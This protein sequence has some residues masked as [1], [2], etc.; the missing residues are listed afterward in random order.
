M[1][2]ERAGGCWSSFDKGRCGRRVGLWGVCSAM[3][4]ARRKKTDDV[5]AGR[6]A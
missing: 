3:E 1:T 2:A 6:G 5:L 4:K